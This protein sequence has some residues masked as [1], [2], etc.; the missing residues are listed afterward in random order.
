MTIG[1][2]AGG[3]LGSARWLG[4]FAL[5]V[6]AVPA[7]A[8]A[9]GPVCASDNAGITVP[10]GFCVVVVADGLGRARHLTVASNGD[11]LV[12]VPGRDSGGVVLLRDTDGDGKADVRRM[13]VSDPQ[14]A[15]VQLYTASGRTWLYYAVSRGILRVPWRV[16]ATATQGAVDTVVRG[17]VYQGQHGIKTFVIAP[18]G[19][20]FVN[21]GAPSN[22]CQQQDRQKGSLG[23]D[24]CPLLDSAGGI[25]LFDANGSDQTSTPTT[26]Y[27]TGLRN[28]VAMAIRPTDSQLYG[29]MHGRD[30]LGALWGYSDSASAEKP[31]EEFVKITEGMDNGWP[32]CYYDPALHEKVLAPEYGGDGTAVGRCGDKA[33]P[34][35]AFPAHWAPDGL[36]FYTGTQFPAAYR[37]GAFVAFHG[38]WNRA[39]LPQQ[40]Y[41]LVFVEF[42]G[43][44]PGKWRVFADGFRDVRSRPVGLAQGPDGSIYVSDDAGG[45]VYRILY[46]GP[47]P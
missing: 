10:D 24:P 46:R 32:Y 19:R 42:T 29:L 47:R 1:G 3:L 13:V 12:A 14:A 38:S 43:E 36:L 33:S 8:R 44:Q 25:W 20:L 2:R 39:P 30:Q 4:A 26:H 18:D 16:G 5:G 22:S 27:A 35:V 17:L 40:G 34:L 15:D 28:T 9:Q 37:G 7:A 21:V 45:R 11:V 23:R 31:A 6:M 41:N